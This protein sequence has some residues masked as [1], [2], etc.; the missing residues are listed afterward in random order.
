MFQS[1]RSPGTSA[2]YVCVCPPRV[3]VVKCDRESRLVVAGSEPRE[4]RRL[5][6]TITV[7]DVPGA[8]GRGAGSP[9][10]RG[11]SGAPLPGR[12]AEA[13]GVVV[14]RGRHGPSRAL[15]ALALASY[16]LH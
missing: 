12:S 7:G 15:H 6:R 1:N 4:S 9:A 14:G 8:W 3:A 13:G 11:W 2:S 10:S 16:I 5:G